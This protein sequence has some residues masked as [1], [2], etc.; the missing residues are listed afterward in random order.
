MANNRSTAEHGEN[1][2][3]E[4]AVFIVIKIFRECCIV[5]FFEHNFI[6]IWAIWV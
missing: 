3:L 6:V 2:F 5:E 4:A 1:I